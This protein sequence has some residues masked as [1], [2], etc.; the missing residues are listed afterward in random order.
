VGNV[1]GRG[2]RKAEAMMPSMPPIFGISMK[3]LELL[4][5]FCYN[6]AIFTGKVGVL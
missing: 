4:L 1:G 2:T 6:R 5:K 3:T